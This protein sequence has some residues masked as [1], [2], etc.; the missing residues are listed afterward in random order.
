MVFS[1]V[2][3]HLLI[4]EL[5]AL[6]DETPLALRP[7]LAALQPL[8]TDELIPPIVRRVKHVLEALYSNTKAEQERKAIMEALSNVKNKT[9]TAPCFTGKT[10]TP[11]SVPLGLADSLYEI[12]SEVETPLA[13]Q[14]IRKI[15]EIINHS[16]TKL[17]EV[18]ERLRFALVANY[19]SSCR[20][21][22]KCTLKGSESPAEPQSELLHQLLL[23][24]ADPMLVNAGDFLLNSSPSITNVSAR[25]V[26][27]QALLGRNAD[28][29]KLIEE[30]FATL[31]ESPVVRQSLAFAFKYTLKQ[32]NL[33]SVPS[34]PTITASFTSLEVG[35]DAKN[36]LY[37]AELFGIRAVGLYN[38][39]YSSLQEPSYLHYLQCQSDD[40]AFIPSMGNVDTLCLNELQRQI[41]QSVLF[42]NNWLLEDVPPSFDPNQHSDDRSFLQLRSIW[43][44]ESKARR[45][46]EDPAVQLLA[47]L[48]ELGLKKVTAS[49]NFVNE[50][51]STWKSIKK[52]DLTTVAA[53]RQL[54][55]IKA[56]NWS[57]PPWNP[58][59]EHVAQYAK[60]EFLWKHGSP[61]QAL[62]LINQ[63]ILSGNQ[64]EGN[65]E[66][67]MLL[68]LR[69][70]KWSWLLRCRTAQ[71][72]NGQFLE[73]LA[74]LSEQAKSNISGDLLAKSHHALA[75]FYDQQYERLRTS[76][77]LHTR[78]RLIKGTEKAIARLN[79]VPHQQSELKRTLQQLQN[80]L[81][82]DRKEVARLTGERVQFALKAATFYSRA[83]QSSCRYDLTASR[84]C[85]LFFALR[86]Q[87]EMLKIMADDN[88]PVSKFVPLIYQL[89]SRAELVE[90]PS[91]EAHFQ[92]TLQRLLLKALVRHPHHA[93]YPVLAL[94]VSPPAPS[95][96]IFESSTP[97]TKRKLVHPSSPSASSAQVRRSAAATSI[98]TR[99][100]AS[101]TALGQLIGD[102]ERLRNALVELASMEL[103][104]DTSTKVT[105]PF[106]ARLLIKKLSSLSCSVPT[107]SLPLDDG[108]LP[109][110]VQSIIDGFRVVGG[111]NLPKIIEMIGSD[112]NIYRQLVKGRDDLR[113]VRIK[114]Q[115]VCNIGA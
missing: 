113:Q 82:Q 20:S 34:L 73:R 92:E 58:Q 57:A 42:T 87:P 70:S 17:E 13:S 2:F 26:M 16:S 37:L 90:T 97:G 80:Q 6:L 29:I 56:L 93:L 40:I 8:I 100:R 15:S 46:Y 38:K 1:G 64:L 4:L 63:A 76:D 102:T 98:I 115:R 48:T 88:L 43:L 23:L 107:A 32:G 61:D 72:I 69:A 49:Q 39:I 109:I 106:E 83:L 55:F 112:G 18:P 81:A 12:C 50:I 66:F 68:L 67:I 104:P 108:V 78:R 47:K 110:T 99:A 53:T 54:R 7:I 77:T 96:S 19:Q 94:G 51:L 3:L 14:V 101:S 111:I 103:A 60:A 41:D 10:T 5:L 91:T 33:R 24:C 28:T 36:V 22:L 105:H 52:V 9:R 35:E 31:I 89:A 74:D 85:S 65:P 11:R 21:V 45:E 27:A 44:G 95:A 75:R 79:A 84:L 59:L 114:T 86:R 30:N 71:E 62:R 25:W